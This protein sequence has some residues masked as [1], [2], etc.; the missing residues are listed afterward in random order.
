MSVSVPGLPESLA[1]FGHETSVREGRAFYYQD[2]PCDQAIYLVAGSVRPVKF[3]PDG[4]PFDLPELRAPCWLGLAELIA[5]SA[6]LFDAV[7]C[8]ECRALSFSR[9]NLSLALASSG[10]GDVS[11]AVM[12]ALASEAIRALRLLSRDDA[13]GKILGYLMSRRATLP[14]VDRARLMLTQAS[15]AESVGLSRET[16]NRQLKELETEGLVTVSRG[17]IGIPDWDSL[18]RYAAERS[19]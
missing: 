16:V 17:E 2:D 8:E 6:Y 7:A 1:R 15:L 13:R 18:A 11:A 14:G 5:G 10:S 19:R 9:K 4:K 3:A 12:E